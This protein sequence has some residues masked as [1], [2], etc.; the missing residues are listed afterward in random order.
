MSNPG[1]RWCSRWGAVIAAVAV[2]GA[3]AVQPA[4]AK[5]VGYRTEA[6]TIDVVDGPAN[7]QH[8]RLDSTVYVPDGAG[9]AHPAPAVIGAHGFGQD[10]QALAGDAAY[11]ARRGYVVLAYSARGFG[12]S[13]G[14][15][16]L[17]SPDYEVKDVRQLVDWLAARP[18][19]RSD[20][21]GPL[22][23]MFGESYAWPPPTTSASG[24][25]SPS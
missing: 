2:L 10:K 11:L 16:G 3:I 13:T 24:P 19:V 20:A 15:I 22:V 25:S 18:E 1:S 9:A 17:D 23:G 5:T 7:D 12:N 4:G 21:A 8:V 14:K 6:H